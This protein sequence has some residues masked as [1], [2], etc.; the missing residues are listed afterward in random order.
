MVLAYCRVGDIYEAYGPRDAYGILR[1]IKTLVFLPGL[2]RQS[3]DVASG[4][5]RWHTALHWTVR[6]Q[7]KQS[8]AEQLAETD[9]V[10]TYERALRDL[11]R[12]RHAIV[13]VGTAPP[14]KFMYPSFGSVR[15]QERTTAANKGTPYVIGFQTAERS[16]QG[17]RGSKS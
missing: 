7:G 11:S 10:S 3:I 1:S 13:L 12:H 4:F 9:L 16:M 15:P 6:R 2:D 5:A 17:D 8:K 14:I